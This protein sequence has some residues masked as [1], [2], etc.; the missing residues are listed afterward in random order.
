M[1]LDSDKL[2]PHLKIFNCM[3]LMGFIL[4]FQAEIPFNLVIISNVLELLCR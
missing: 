4:F 1:H 2:Y 3:F